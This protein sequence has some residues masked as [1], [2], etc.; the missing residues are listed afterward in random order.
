M[1]VKEAFATIACLSMLLSACSREAPSD[2][3]PPA[4]AAMAPPVT[5][6]AKVDEAIGTGAPIAPGQTAI[7]HYTGWLYS[8]SAPENKGEKFDSSRDRGQPF[9][10]VV[11]GG[12]VI[13]GWDEGVVGMQ[14]G[15]RR[16]LTIP[17]ELGYGPG[18]ARNVI[19]PNAVLLFDVE[20]LG[21]KTP[22]GVP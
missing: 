14:V 5:T 6:L 4:G 21:I 13:K 15:G 18:G 7:V 2:T 12:T 3:A 22:N 9:E 19:P 1:T 17:P 16:R 10:F 8:T 11:G 20:L